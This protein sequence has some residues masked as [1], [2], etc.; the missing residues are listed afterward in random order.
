MI[1]VAMLSTYWNHF[2]TRPRY[3]WTNLVTKFHDDKTINEAS[4]VLSTTKL[5]TKFH[6][7]QT[8]NM[9]SRV[10]T[11]KNARSHV[12][13]Q[14][15]LELVEDFI[16][17]KCSDQVSWRLDYINVIFRVKNAR[18]LGGHVFQLTRNTSNI[19]G[20]LLVLT[21]KNASPLGGHVFQATRT[22]LELFHDD[23][24]IKAKNAP[25]PGGHVFQPNRTIFKLVTYITVTNLL[26]RFREYRTINV[27]SRVLTRQV[28]TPQDTQW[29]KGVII[30]SKLLTNFHDYS[31]I[32]WNRRCTIENAGTKGDHKKST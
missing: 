21:R 6:D 2:Q 10:F 24:S 11:M 29:A 12:F 14:T 1:L 25:P 27:A 20:Q 30:G 8:T 26:I 7:N 31:A 16:R 3:H 4:I 22:I 32:N 15:I 5:L 13:Q 23:R 9:A 18:P 28:L 17:R 19:L